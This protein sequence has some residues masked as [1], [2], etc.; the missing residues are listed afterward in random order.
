MKNFIFTIYDTLNVDRISEEGLFKFMLIMSNRVP[1]VSS[2]PTDLMNLHEYES[3]MFLDFFS[4][5]FCKI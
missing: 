3:D 4:D 2:N 1:G 5:D